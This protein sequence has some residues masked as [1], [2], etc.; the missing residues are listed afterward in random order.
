MR[1][2]AFTCVCLLPMIAFGADTQ[3][4][5]PTTSPA[6]TSA[7]FDGPTRD[8]LGRLDADAISLI[9]VQF[10]GRWSIMDTLAREQLQQMYGRQTIEGLPPALA[11]LEIYCNAGQYLDK[12][13]I[14]IKDSNLREALAQALPQAWRDRFR[15]DGWRLPPACFM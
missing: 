14:Y 10:H 3:A 11:Y 13:L 12:P 2:L 8:F 5:M 4:T 7:I 9:P 6:A 1:M 15:A